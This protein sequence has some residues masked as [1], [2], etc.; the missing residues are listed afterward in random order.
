MKRGFGVIAI[1]LGVGLMIGNAVG[2]P[3]WMNMPPR[4]GWGM[5]FLFIYFGWMW[6]KNK[7]KENTNS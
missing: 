5:C 4:F 7:P 1:L 3:D 2:F 6:V